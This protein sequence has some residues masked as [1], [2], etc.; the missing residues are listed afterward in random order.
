MRQPQARPRTHQN[1]PVPALLEAALRRGEGILTSA[2]ALAVSTGK[3]T[4]RSP[5]DRYIVD[6]AEVHDAVGYE[7]L[8]HPP[9]GPP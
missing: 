5:E 7:R 9:S 8:R 2:G 3:Y 6:D 1:P 4:G